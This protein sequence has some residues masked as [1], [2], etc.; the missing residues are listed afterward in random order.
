MNSFTECPDQ[1]TSGRIPMLRANRPDVGIRNG[2]G[3][4]EIGVPDF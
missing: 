3:R 4:N 2:G 1:E